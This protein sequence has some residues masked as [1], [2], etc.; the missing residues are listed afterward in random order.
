MHFQ[1]KLKKRNSNNREKRMR[2]NI[3]QAADVKFQTVLMRV[4]Y[5]VP[6]EEV[7]GRRQVADDQRIEASFKTL[8][9]LL[10]NQAKVILISHL[11]RPK[12]TEDADLSLKP[13]ADHL[14][15][16]LQQPVEFVAD[17][18]GKKARATVAALRPGS[19]IL[20]ENL[21]FHEGEERNDPKFAQKLASLADIYIDEAFSA[22]HRAHAS[23]VG[24]AEYLPSFAGFALAEEV[25][26]LSSLMEA[27]ARPLV[28]VLGGAKI[29][30]KVGAVK[31]LAKIADIVLVGGAV[32]N[33]FLKAEGLEI[34]RSYLED[35]PADLNK[36]NIDY[37][38]FAQKLIKTHKNERMLKDGYL[39]LPKILYPIDVMA[40]KNME[41]TQK[42]QTQIF[43]LSSGMQDEEENEPLAYYDIGPKTIQLYQEII[44]QAGTV[45]WNGPMGVW[46]NPLFAAG[47]K[48]IAQA[49]A[50]NPHT[51]I[52]GGGDTISAI[53]HF[54]LTEKF[55]Y[56]SAAG[57]A[58][59]DF[60]S[61]KM[62]PGLK[63]V[64]KNHHSDLV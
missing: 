51:T 57:G 36:K 46:E 3:P 48:I 43:D 19:A 50:K 47:T 9:F 63:V 60:L 2:L 34:F 10:E 11:G 58:A 45:F 28:I 35:A 26:Q 59:L 12:S 23:T 18:V 38:K 31:H 27:P 52:V 14:K 40:A 8:Q 44:A 13:I 25:E 54:G 6:L 24:V 7:D 49:I 5:N 39:P 32:A 17:L 33:N 4:D 53:E 42:E 20:L 1:R 21:R 29:S 62:L 56:V 61:G 15:N 64:S 22:A 41:I 30:D 37:V 55:K 16:N